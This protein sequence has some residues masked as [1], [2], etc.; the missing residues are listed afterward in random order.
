MQIRQRFQSRTALM[1]EKIGSFLKI[2]TELGGYCTLEQAKA[3]ELAN[4]NTRVLAH[5]RGLERAGFVRRVADYPVV[6]QITGATTRLLDRDRR[7][8]RVHDAARVLSRLL[9]VSFYLE[10]RLWPADFAFDHQHK[11]DT[12]V[13][14]GCPIDALPQRGGKPYLW[15]EL[16]LWHDYNRIGVAIMD[17]QQRSPLSQLKGFARGFSHL[18]VCL[19][20]R[21]RMLI[22]TGAESRHLIY[23]RLVHHPAVMKFSPPGFAITIEPYQ[24][25]NAPKS[26]QL[27][28]HENS[29]EAVVASQPE[30]QQ[31]RR[32]TSQFATPATV[33]TEIVQK[34]VT[35]AGVTSGTV[36]LV[37]P[38]PSKAE[39]K[40][41]VAKNGTNT[42][43]TAPPFRFE[44]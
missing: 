42:K 27:L 33:M 3:L 9:A 12:F 17:D 20:K 39:S 40:F 24:M 1:D 28:P 31:P 36:P 35:R 29:Q 44:D 30:P 11:I 2:V 15:E 4:S 18:V 10:A 37:T 32:R 26:L 21:L 38:V 22:V 34:A 43:S 41:P 13:Y 14:E 19:G 7:A 8:R 5:L 23:C 6:C 25:R 16:V